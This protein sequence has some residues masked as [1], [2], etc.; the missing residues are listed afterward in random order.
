[1]N[2]VNKCELIVDSDVM[3]PVL[4]LSLSLS[5]FISLSLSLSLAY[6]RSRLP[7]GVLDVLGESLETQRLREVVRSLLRG[8]H[9]DEL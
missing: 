5:L 9:L 3:I 4:S 7:H 6:E 1:M 2:K 8:V